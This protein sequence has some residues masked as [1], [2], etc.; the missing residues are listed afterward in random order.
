MTINVT[1]LWSLIAVEVCRCWETIYYKC[2]TSKSLVCIGPLFRGLVVPSPP[3]CSQ[4]VEVS[5]GK[6]LDP[7]T[8]RLAILKQ[9]KNQQDS[10]IIFPGPNKNP[11]FSLPIVTNP[12]SDFFFHMYL[13]VFVSYKPIKKQVDMAK[14]EMKRLI[15]NLFIFIN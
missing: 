6:L 8:L 7:A 15:I 5:L 9:T 13:M 2:C 1:N 3:T 4:H 10:W 11:A 14:N 12:A